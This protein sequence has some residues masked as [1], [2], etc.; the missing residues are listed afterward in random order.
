MK[1][2]FI[3]CPRKGRTEENFKNSVEK[4]HK[5]AEL[6][7]GE[8]LEIV[9]DFMLTDIPD[10]ANEDIWQLHKN[11]K[12]MA[13]A[14]Y[15]IGVQQYVDSDRVCN[16]EK[17]IAMEKCIKN[18]LVDMDLL[19]PDFVILEKASQADRRWGR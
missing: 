8:E 17:E 12:S 4:M 19:M 7:F 15:F 2:L 16:T 10:G 1:K 18:T 14:D 9:N 13:F 3:S 5:I 11:L 6:T